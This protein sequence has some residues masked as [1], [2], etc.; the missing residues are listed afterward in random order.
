VLVTINA[1]M[2][3][4]AGMLREANKMLFRFTSKVGC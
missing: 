1:K 4:T 2:K 3:T